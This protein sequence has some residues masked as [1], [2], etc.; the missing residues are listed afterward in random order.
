MSARERVRRARAALLGTATGSALLWGAASLAG[1]SL[2]VALVDWRWGLDPS[3]RSVLRALLVATAIIVAAWVLW[4]SRRVRSE[5]AVALWIEERHPVLRYALVTALDPDAGVAREPLER[6]VATVSWRDALRGAAGRALGAP[7]IALLLAALLLGALPR[8]AVGRLRSPRV[9]DTPHIA[10]VPTALRGSHLAPL[11]A[12]VTPPAYTGDSARVLR[13]PAGVAA[14]VGSRV[15]LSAPGPAA[16]RANIDGAAF[17]VAGVG[18]RWQLTLTM[19]RRAAAVRL[20][21]GDHERIVVLEPRLDSAP[22][23]TL[24]LPARDTLLR[25]PAGGLV[26]AAT[27][28]DDIGLA[29]GWFEYIV[30][31][32]EEESFTFRS[33]VIGRTT[34]SG[35]RARLESRLLLDSLHLAPGDVVHLR[36]VARDHNNITGPGVGTS[37]TRTIRVPRHDEGDSVS[38]DP[39]PPPE[40]EKSALSQRMLIRLTEALVQRRP[41]LSRGAL[42][43]ESRRIA[44]DQTALRKMVGTIIFTRI[45]VGSNEESNAGSDSALSG[46]LTPD[47]LLRAADAATGD[48]AGRALDFEEGESPVVA[49]NRPLLEAYNAMW[50]AG[51]S[52]DIAEPTAALPYMYAA[53][54]AIQRARAAERLYLRG[55]TPTVVLDLAKIRLAGARDGVAAAPRSPRTPLD[56][57]GGSAARLDAALRQL[58]TT[59]AAA[60]DSLLILRAAVL[61]DAP[62][63]AVALGTAIDSL[64]AGRDATAVLLQARRLV[65]PAP[66]ATV[67]LPAWSGAP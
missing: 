61:G 31:S 26:L 55:K 32:G 57:L 9:G 44:T 39:A 41:R 6:V 22:A 3:A 12:T 48:A 36:A 50:E 20:G 38:I 21:E 42:A 46:A 7:S 10:P 18:D 2:A 5:Q 64:R 15:V 29:E 47:A 33:G 40:A 25:T 35:V 52:L 4:R 66:V 60:V 17:P 37:D 28:R 56:A 8:G 13:E 67:G 30:S 54:A 24:E 1:G 63:L 58:T 34:V 62:A 19:P 16:I 65:S 14:L 23:V 53:L 27:L 11:T 59:P 43:S 45:G 51:R 49:V